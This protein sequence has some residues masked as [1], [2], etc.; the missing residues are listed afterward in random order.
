MKKWSANQLIPVHTLVEDALVDGEQAVRVV[1]K[2]K[3]E[4]PDENTYAACRGVALRDG[5]VQLRLRSR[6]LPDAPEYARGFVGL[7]FRA[8]ADG[9]EFESFYV[10]PTNGRD[11][12]DPVRRAHGCQYFSYPGYTFG[13]FREF[14]ITAYEAPVELSLDEWF[15]LK[16]V[17]RGR[18][19][20]FYV[21]E[22]LA[23]T[24]EDLKHGSGD[25]GMLGVYVDV[26]TEAFLSGLEI[27]R[28]E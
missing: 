2:D 18:H 20:E 11:C 7:V 25:A 13:Y 23:L 5:V 6:L 14:G 16:A 12:T 1:K 10:R 9:S 3:V 8:K 24:V 22:K 26:G 19:A 28:E 17:I 27:V 4:Q 15:T 21:N